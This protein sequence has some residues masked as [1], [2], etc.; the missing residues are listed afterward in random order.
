MV[1]KY[2]PV[3]VEALKELISWELKG[4]QAQARRYICNMLRIIAAGKRLDDDRPGS[5]FT[6]LIEDLYQSPFKIESRETGKDIV[7]A[8]LRGYYDETI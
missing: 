2:R 6:D 8:L 7:S 3:S 4:E 1:Y 5:K